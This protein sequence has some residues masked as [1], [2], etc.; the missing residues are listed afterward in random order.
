MP[1][2]PQTYKNFTGL[3][4]AMD[5][6]L[7]KPG[8]LSECINAVVD[9]GILRN[10]G[11]PV[12]AWDANLGTPANIAT[13][14]EPF[15]A[16]S[17]GNNLL[18]FSSDYNKSGV[19]GADPT[20]YLVFADADGH[21]HWYDYGGSWSTLYSTSVNT[22]SYAMNVIDGGIYFG[23]S[24]HGNTARNQIFKPYFRERFGSNA[25][26]GLGNN[27]GSASAST[28]AKWVMTNMKVAMPIAGT[29]TSGIADSGPTAVKTVNSSQT[30][31]ISVYLRWS[32][33]GNIEPEW[34]KNW[35]V[36]VSLMYGKAE[37]KI[38][39]LGSVNLTAEDV[40]GVAFNLGCGIYSSG[41]GTFPTGY[42]DSRITGI[43]LYLREGG[44]D[45][46]SLHGVWD[47]EEGGSE[48]YA[49]NNQSWTVVD[50][51]GA[52]AHA[53]NS[54]S[55][56]DVPL[57][58][59]FDSFSQTGHSNDVDYPFIGHSGAGYKTGVLIGKIFWTANI[60]RYTDGELLARPGRVQPSDPEA[61]EKF[62]QDK[63]FDISLAEGDRIVKIDTWAERLLIWTET[64]F[65]VYNVSDPLMPKQEMILSNMGVNAQC[66]V[67]HTDLGIISANDFGCYMFNNSGIKDLL[68]RN[69]VRMIPMYAKD[70]ANAE[71]YGSTRPWAGF[72]PNGAK[73]MVGY[74]PLSKQLIL[75]RGAN[76][77]TGHIYVINMDNG[78]IAYGDSKYATVK[79][80]NFVNNHLGEL[81][82]GEDVSD[83]TMTMYRWNGE[84]Q[85]SGNIVV[86]FNDDDFN[87]P[88]RDKFVYGAT[89]RRRASATA[90]TPFRYET[91]GIHHASAAS[92]DNFDT[93]ASGTPDLTSSAE[94][95]DLWCPI[96]SKIRCTS[97]RMVI[98]IND[99]GIY[100]I[101]KVTPEFRLLKASR[102][103]S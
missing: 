20:R 30:P 15:S 55:F 51:S 23:N 70:T 8:D 98:D 27:V 91:N 4:M 2:T 38:R 12:R 29:L 64:K 16:A 87:A 9:R 101:A 11:A 34:Q 80:T 83:T 94:F 31:S 19:L 6:S 59:V 58:G 21:I 28:A 32:E 50:S 71:L 86:M 97:F 10:M 76:G 90:Q 37:S 35:H 3:N 39:S 24:G 103:S 25:K 22:D 40:T 68:E 73:T 78:A 81:I 53:K 18:Y 5:P 61:Y 82:C 14:V 75:Q 95:S 88:D 102:A 84:P 72:T 33:S 52:Y 96:D 77:Y 48:P 42:I 26:Y 66:G 46:W 41:G 43:K 54:S 89:I 63:G 56:M 74:D 49:G 60:I 99:A 13:K 45:Q 62:V 93:N 79:R 57:R 69:G 65:L 7:L 47:I 36:G 17:S 92:F 85:S 67:C 1:R 44:S 100:E